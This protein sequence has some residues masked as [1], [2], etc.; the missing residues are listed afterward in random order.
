M[1]D[2]RGGGRGWLS[3]T[4]EAAVWSRVSVI[5]GLRFALEGPDLAFLFGLRFSPGRDLRQ[6][7]WV[8]A[9]AAAYSF[10]TEYEVEAKAGYTFFESPKITISLGA[11]P[12]WEIVS[13]RL[14]VGVSLGF[15]YLFF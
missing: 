8:S 9:T 1:A 14:G 10:H 3:L 4:G 15:G 11:G 7:F 6:G 13:G 12:N 2:V 5:Y